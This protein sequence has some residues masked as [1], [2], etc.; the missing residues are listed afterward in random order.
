MPAMNSESPPNRDP[1]PLGPR[2]FSH[3]DAVSLGFFIGVLLV[4]LLAASQPAKGQ[5]LQGH[6]LAMLMVAA[7]G[8]YAA[9]TSWDDASLSF[10]LGE[11]L[12]LLGYVATICGLGAIAWQIGQDPTLLSAPKVPEVLAR[13]ALALL[14]TV[15]GLIGMNYLRMRGQSLESPRAQAELEARQIAEQLEQ[16][17]RKTEVERAQTFLSAFQSADLTQQLGAMT[18]QLRAAAEALAAFRTDSQRVKKTW[19]EMLTGLSGLNGALQQFQE[20]AEGLSASWAALREQLQQAPPLG[21]AAQEATAALNQ[22]GSAAGPLQQM[23]AA[24][25]QVL[26]PLRSD[27]L[28]AAQQLQERLNQLPPLA[29]AVARF[30]ELA[31]QVAP[32]LRVLGDSY[33]DISNINTYLHHA[34]TNLQSFNQELIA[35]SNATGGLAAHS[36]KLLKSTDT[37]VAEIANQVHR[38]KK[39]SGDLDQLSGSVAMLAPALQPLVPQI[40]TL[41]A[42]S[43]QLNELVQGVERTQQVLDSTTAKL[44]EVPAV[45]GNFITTTRHLLVDSVSVHSR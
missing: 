37:L 20:R 13:G 36:D 38:L 16:V 7:F 44:E 22:L 15:I 19:A 28:Q 42:F 34:V 14:S 1:G 21:Q 35:S 32:T 29:E 9:W 12:Y 3:W 41:R 43:V 4:S 30:V 45:V 8:V 40:E 23:A 2:K 17:L 39:L 31:N 26:G 33:Q 5:S 11:T 10:R 24:I 6:L 27:L 18:E 25:L